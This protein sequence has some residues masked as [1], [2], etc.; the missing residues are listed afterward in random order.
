MAEP[1]DY[2]FQGAN[3]GM[4]AGQARIQQ[5]QFRT[6]L[7]ERARQFDEQLKL[8]ELNAELRRKEF[9]LSKDRFKLNQEYTGLQIDALDAQNKEDERRLKQAKRTAPAIEKWRQDNFDTGAFDAFTPLPPDLEGWQID[10][11]N[12]QML[13]TRQ[14]QQQNLRNK[15]TQERKLDDL[16]TEN[17][18]ADWAIKNGYKDVVIPSTDDPNGFEINQE[19]LRLAQDDFRKREEAEAASLAAARNPNNSAMVANFFRTTYDQ[20][21][22]PVRAGEDELG[23]PIIKDVYDQKGHIAYVKNLMNMIQSIGGAP[24]SDPGGE[25]DLDENDKD[26]K[27]GEKDGLDPTLEDSEIDAI[28]EAEALRQPTR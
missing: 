19:A 8:Q 7:A 26:G 17:A 14:I 15:I 13:N 27:P 20:F 2:F 4:R 16:S 5:E 1:L 11:L 23:V 12:Q 28:L 6:N 9:K 25:P 21:V 3:L 10:E 18:L 24:S 22:N